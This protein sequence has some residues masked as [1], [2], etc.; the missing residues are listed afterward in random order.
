MGCARVSGV[1][2]A[3]ERIASGWVATVRLDHR[4]KRC[5]DP[6]LPSP[7]PRGFTVPDW[8]PAC[9]WQWAPARI[10][11]LCGLRS[12]QDPQLEALAGAFDLIA[13]LWGSTQD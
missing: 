12:A 5:V 7:N 13:F 6:Q 9:I 11:S 2:R 3:G 10:R 4:E 1:H 8:D